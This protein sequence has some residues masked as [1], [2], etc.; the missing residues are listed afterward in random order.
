MVDIKNSIRTVPDFPIEG[1][2]FRDITGLLEDT[3]AFNKCLIDLTAEIMLFKGDVI[4]GIESRGFLFGTPLAR[5]IEIPFV[6]ARKPG[7]LPNKTVSKK[8]DLE[9]GKAELQIQLLSPINGKVIII[10][11]LIATGGTALACASLIHENWNIPKEDILI[12]AVIDLPNLGG[13]AIIQDNGYN[14]RT[15]VEFDG[16]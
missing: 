2:Q 6:L 1:I 13:S 8:Y 12:L 14:V 11:D 5:D 10:D 15:L 7:K 3:E 16:E 9:Y 4:V